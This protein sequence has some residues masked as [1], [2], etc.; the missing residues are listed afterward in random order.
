MQP[1]HPKIGTV[2]VGHD[3]HSGHG[4]KHAVVDDYPIHFGLVAHK[5]PESS[6]A[7]PD[8]KGVLKRRRYYGQ[9]R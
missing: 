6:K 5:A 8:Q 7:P 3:V 1:G 9:E 2:V 4:Y